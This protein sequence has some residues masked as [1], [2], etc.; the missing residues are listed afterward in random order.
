MT[1]PL[2]DIASSGLGGSISS[3][4][5]RAHLAIEVNLSGNIFF[6]SILKYFEA[7]SKKLE[8]FFGILIFPR[9]TKYFQVFS[10]L[11]DYLSL[12]L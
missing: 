5:V 11:F 6:R 2:S 9:I 10:I 8:V 4:S 7:F 12:F 3:D 1:G